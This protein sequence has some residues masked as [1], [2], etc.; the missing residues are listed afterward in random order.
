MA[1]NRETGVMVAQPSPMGLI[2]AEQQRAIAEVQAAMILARMTPRDEQR[3]ETRILA[4]C[5]RPSFVE[6]SM[7]AF[8]KGGTDISG[9]S[10][11]TAQAMARHWGNIQYGTREVE[12][13][14]GESVMQS[15]CWDL[16]TNV[17]KEMVFTVRHLRDRRDGPQQLTSPRDIYEL[18]A[19]QGSRRTRACILGIIPEELADKARQKIEET[20][21]KIAEPTPDRVKR[22]L[23]FFESL[24][25]S[26]GQ[27][28]AVVQRKMDALK[29]IHMVRLIKI[30]NSLRDGMSAPGDWFK[31]ASNVVSM[32]TRK[33]GGKAD[34]EPAASET[35]PASDETTGASGETAAPETE[36]PGPASE[37]ASTS[38]EP[39]PAAS[40]APADPATIKPLAYGDGQVVHILRVWRPNPQKSGHCVETSDGLAVAY[41]AK[42]VAA[43]EEVAKSNAPVTLRY[44]RTT[45]QPAPVRIEGVSVVEPEKKPRGNG[46]RGPA[47][48]LELPDAADIFGAGRE[49]GQEG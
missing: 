27:V 47:K 35:K 25:V 37:T 40:A 38:A 29:P 21:L 22:I 45:F 14:D 6:V 7:Y 23:A 2:S 30:A 26:Q 4:D 3:A 28:E 9:L 10:I 24:G 8:A 49:P 11:H 15:Y 46:R 43:L 1:D 33:S 42:V 19:N 16:E 20:L 39:A 18:T 32:P 44:T 36:T 5:E 12:Q 13:S 31:G 17:K 34:Q 48:G 41:D